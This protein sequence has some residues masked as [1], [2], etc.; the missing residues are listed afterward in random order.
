MHLGVDE[1]A[2]EGLNL[3]IKCGVMFMSKETVL[4]W[5][6]FD[7]R[8]GQFADNSEIVEVREAGGTGCSLRPRMRLIRFWRTSLQEPERIRTCR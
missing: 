1:E 2:N 5:P 8:T 3:N 6:E 4:S 7:N